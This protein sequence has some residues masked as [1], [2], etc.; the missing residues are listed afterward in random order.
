MPTPTE[1]SHGS[2]QPRVLQRRIIVN[3]VLSRPNP[4]PSRVDCHLHNFNSV[5]DEIA[6]QNDEH[7]VENEDYS[8]DNHGSADVCLKEGRIE[9]G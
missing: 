2:N 3:I 5:V 6:G 1:T 8:K 4:S 9:L 7:E